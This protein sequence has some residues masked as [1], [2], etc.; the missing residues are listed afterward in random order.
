[1]LLSKTI[2][3]NR[4]QI[5]VEYIL[6][7]FVAVSISASVVSIM[8]SRD[9]DSP[10]FLIRAWDAIVVTI[11]NDNPGELQQDAN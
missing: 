1:M 9:E 10:G 6:L 5:A 4:A 8:V 3:N 11:S 7:V 2:R